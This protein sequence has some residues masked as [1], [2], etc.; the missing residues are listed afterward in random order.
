MCWLHS[1]LLF[2]NLIWLLS[3]SFRN[4]SLQRMRRLL[5]SNRRL[6]GR[7]LFKWVLCSMPVNWFYHM[8]LQVQFHC[9]FAILRKLKLVCMAFALCMILSLFWKFL[10][11]KN[12]EFSCFLFLRMPIKSSGRW[13]AALFLCKR[14]SI[15][16]LGKRSWV[17]ARVRDWL[18]Y[19]G[20]KKLD[21]AMSW[22]YMSCGCIS[23]CIGFFLL[24][25]L[26]L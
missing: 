14:A 20:W 10:S 16:I 26:C 2:K 1:L 18:R 21:T 9:R 25:V 11:W 4:S 8:H 3:R 24:H 17:I 5:S 23:W 13:G 7:K 6:L 15:A 22:L 12:I 19:E